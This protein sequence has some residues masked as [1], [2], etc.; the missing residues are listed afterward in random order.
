MGDNADA[1]PDD[2]AETSDSDGDGVGDNGDAFPEDPAETADTDGDGVGDNGDAFPDDPDEAADTDGDG[3]GDNADPDADG[4]GVPDE[5]DL[6]PLDP[7]KADIGSYVF[8]SE[9]RLGGPSDWGVELLA[10]GGDASTLVFGTPDY[11]SHRGAAYVLAVADLGVLDAADGRVDREISLANAV[12]GPASWKF[13]GESDW[14]VAGTSLAAADMDGDGVRDLV[15]GASGFD[16]PRS[17]PNAG[18]VYLLSGR[19]VAAADAADGA[20]DHR[21]SLGHVAAQPHSWKIVG[22][23]HCAM[24]GSEV[25]AGNLDEDRALELVIGAPAGRNCYTREPRRGSV[26]VVSLGDL[27][28]ADTADGRTDGVVRVG[29]VAQEPHS[30]RFI[31][32]TTEDDVGSALALLGDMDDDGRTDFAV[33]APYT[34]VDDRGLRGRAF[35]VSSV[36]MPVADAAD[37]N[38]D[39]LVRFARLAAQSGSWKLTADDETRNPLGRRIAVTGRTGPDGSR[40]ILVSGN[41]THLV[42]LGDLP[43]ADAAD[44]RPDGVVT[45]ESI[46]GA[47]NSWT[48]RNVR[49]ARF[50]GDRDGDAALLIAGSREASLVSMAALDDLDAA[51][52]ETDRIVQSQHLGRH[53]G[54]W[55]LRGERNGWLEVGGAGDVDGDGRTDAFL[56][57]RYGRDSGLGDRVYLVAA[58]D[59]S[60]LDRADGIPDRDLL[61]GSVAGDTDDDGINNTLDRDDDNDGVADAEDAFQLDPAEWADA[62]GD[63]VGDNADAFP[64]DWREQV[65]TDGDGVGDN[66]DED[67]DGD[68]VPDAE[69]DRPLDTDDD[70]TDN[71]DDPD[72]DNDGV[73]D[74]DDDLPLD[75]A[76]T[77]DTDGDGIGDNADRDDDN[78]GVPDAE[79]DLPLDPAETVDSDGDGTGDNADAFPDD[80]GEQSD[81]DGDGVGDNA[82][83]DDDNDG[84][85]DAEDDFPLDGS[86]ASDSDGDGVPDSRDAFPADPGEWAD[87]DGDGTGDN[88]DADDDGDGVA[89][90]DDLFPLDPDRWRLTSLRLLAEDSGRR[91]GI[92]V[93]APGD[94]DDDGRPDLL[95]G[96]PGAG[97]S[98]GAYIVSSRDWRS[99]DDADGVH[100]GSIGLEHVPRETHSWQLAGEDGMAAGVAVS[101]AGDLDGDGRPEFLVGASA[102]RGAVYVVSALDLP[103][104]DAADGEADGVAG[105]GAVAAGAGSWRLGGAWGDRTG[106]SLARVLSGA[107]REHLLLGQPG[108]GTGARHGTVRLV[109]AG[110]LGVLDGVDG[111][112]DGAVAFWRHDG[113]WVFEGEEE[114]DAAGARVALADVDGDGEP[115]VVVGAPEHDAARRANGAVYV[116]ASRDFGSQARFDLGEVPGASRS[117]KIVGENPADGLGAALA[118]GDVDGDGVLDLVLGTRVGAASGVVAYVLSG[119]LANLM[120]LDGADG[121]LGGVVRLDRLG[122][123]DGNVRLTRTE[124]YGH[125]FPWAR[126]VATPDVDGDGRADL[127]LALAGRSGLAFVLLPARVVDDAEAGTL[128][129]DAALAVPSAYAF[130]SGAGVYPADGGTGR[131]DALAVANAG[132]V[133]DDGLEDLLLGVAHGGRAAVFLIVAADLGELDAADGTVDDRIELRRVVGRRE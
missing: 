18:A 44:G 12:A 96:V 125:G 95:I 46:A 121:G 20:I 68:G 7:A 58:A 37:G 86:A 21:V 24:V 112:A 71:A 119:T 120:A 77:V 25:V 22:T 64:T 92:S 93:A 117:Y 28:A 81:S 63:G 79:D 43:A 85:P 106:T 74:E 116:V 130:V 41:D 56:T 49:R 2:P 45:A 60:A 73:N 131:P 88:A 87:S 59:V 5:I 66:A 105:L 67:D 111:D 39:G 50:L 82:D 4:D 65:D 27:P 70:G 36:D 9:A 75:P 94:L 32:E 16:P 29:R 40:E 126:R 91:A 118:T 13:V 90:S 107:D 17:W 76:E 42:S 57:Q 133:D 109:E 3:I 83:A 89:D 123:V 26:Y 108:S 10:T 124:P 33:G 128:D 84:V 62:D 34:Y 48:L 23:T 14:H 101:G 55:R 31:G 38:A 113:P 129:I 61:L 1:F 8:V 72:D 35:L 100:D 99:A 114:L 78:D 54:T 47:P 102:L 53:D 52:G 30:Y 80:P 6:F 51:D 127:L 69:D 19:D 97:E 132:D 122:S 110:E 98:G 103:A 115:D 104:A 11:D 15:I